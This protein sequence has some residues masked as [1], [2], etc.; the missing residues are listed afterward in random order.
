MINY[1]SVCGE[2]LEVRTAGIRVVREVSWTMLLQNSEKA[3][4]WRRGRM[5]GESWRSRAGLPDRKLALNPA[6]DPQDK[7]TG[8]GDS[9]STSD[10]I[11][12]LLHLLFTHNEY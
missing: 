9:D 12:L 6:E 3:K 8:K 7:A 10:T 11:Y 5:E 2:E 1:M 4:R